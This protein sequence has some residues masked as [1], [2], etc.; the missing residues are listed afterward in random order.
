LS[1]NEIFRLRPPDTDFSI[2]CR[3]QR[4]FNRNLSYLKNTPND[5][6]QTVSRTYT[7]RATYVLKVCRAGTSTCSNAVTLVFD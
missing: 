2:R 1:L 7:G 3:E 5:G 6:L 4:P